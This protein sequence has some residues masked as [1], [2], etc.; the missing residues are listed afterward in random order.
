MEREENQRF[1]TVDDAGRAK[2]PDEAR[3][4]I[5]L[6]AASTFMERGYG[7]SSVDDVAD[8]LGATKG[9]IYHY[10]K[11]KTDIFLH[12]H[13]EALRVLL[14]NVGAEAAR[15]DL[16]PKDRLFEMCR[17]HATVFMTTVSYQKTSML[18][19]NRF[20]LSITHPYQEAS[21][22]RIAQMRKEYEDL[23]VTAIEDGI[24]AGEFR[25]VPAR[26]ATKPLLGSLNWANIWYEPPENEDD[27]TKYVEDVSVALATYC[28][29]AVIKRDPA[30]ST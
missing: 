6:A 17:C 4:K 15:T 22:K 5:L 19:P 8:T 28:L 25:D 29:N 16:T 14:E 23:F 13:Q 1:I 10:Y 20:L 2:A 3:T 21:G 11:S 18:G 30:L 7:E 27:K 12:I 24:S 9:R 26:V